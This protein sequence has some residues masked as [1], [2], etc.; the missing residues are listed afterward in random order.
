MSGVQ[1]EITADSQG[2]GQNVGWVDTND[3]M[4]YNGINIPK[5]GNYIIK[6]RVASPNTG[7]KLSVDLNAGATLLG[8]VDIPNTG[9]WQNWVTVTQNVYI[10]AGTYNFGIF[11]Q[12]GGWNINWFQITSQ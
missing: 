7:G 10:N 6:Y 3:W 12:A 5:S 8:T 9:G 4:A 1:A 11:A 2:G